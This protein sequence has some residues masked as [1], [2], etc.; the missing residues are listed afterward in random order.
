MASKIKVDQIE[1][2]AGSS[3]TIPSGQ[4]LT[5]TDGLA[6][7]TIGSGTLADARIPNLNAS[8]INAGTFADARIADLAATK[9][10]GTIADAR[11][12]TVPV[13][14]GG[15]GLTS[16]GSAGQ[17]VQVNS[18]ASA[19]EFAAASSGKVK[20]IQ[21]ANTSAGVTTTSGTHQLVSGCTLNITPNHANN[22]III[23]ACIGE[24]D[25]TDGRLSCHIF[26]NNTAEN[27]HG[28][29]VSEMG[30]G[31]SNTGTETH[32]SGTGIHFVDVAGST[33][34]LTYDL[35]VRSGNGNTVR[36]GNGGSTNIMAME[37]EV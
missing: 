27:A 23:W 18:G 7:S 22:L 14:K 25:Q 30:R 36:T 32:R 21:Y 10:T 31:L 8:K 4:T 19:L 33:N 12:P 29:L 34:Q 24:P 28:R 15:T 26:K 6:A 9:L 11:L 2:S 17:V 20:Q 37:I 5:I 13:A 35:R 3:I 16:L 1:G